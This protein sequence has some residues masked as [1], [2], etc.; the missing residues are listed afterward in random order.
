MKVCIKCKLPKDLDQY[1]KNKASKDGLNTRCKLCLHDK[2]INDKLKPDFILKRNKNFK[3]HRDNNPEYYKRK[4]KENY[5]NNIDL[6]KIKNKIPNKLNET[7]DLDH[8]IPISSAKTEEDVLKLN[9]YTNFQPLCSY[10][11][12]YIKINNIEWTK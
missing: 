6:W 8:K 4:D 2:Y 1:S 3:K 12:R 10:T 7:W 5:Q 11:N 9:H